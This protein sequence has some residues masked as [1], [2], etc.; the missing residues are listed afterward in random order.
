LAQSGRNFCAIGRGIALLSPS[1]AGT[2]SA[3]EEI[4]M[5]EL[6]ESDLHPEIADEALPPAATQEQAFQRIIGKARMMP[7]GAKVPALDV[8][9]AYVNAM[10]GYRIIEPWLPK[11]RALREADVAA[12]ESV[13]DAAAGL[14]FAKR[15]V[16]LIVPSRPLSAQLLR[17]RKLRVALLRQAQAAAA[18]DLIAEAPVERIQRGQGNI[19]A[20]EDLVALVELYAQNDAALAGRTL[21]TPALLAEAAELGASLQAELR[22]KHAPSQ[23]KDADGELAKATDDKHHITRLLI[24]AYAE[25]ERVARYLRIQRV[26]TLQSRKALRKK[27]AAPA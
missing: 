20:A 22:P 17:G 4:D 25:L 5:T 1:W 6:E 24:D 14:L 16:A 9:L 19:D 11:I 7:I 27:K 12:I 2:V 3:H 26:P 23:A 21:I 10:D 8:R 15:R 13:A 18:L